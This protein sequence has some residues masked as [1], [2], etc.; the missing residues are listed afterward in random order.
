[1]RVVD[2]SSQVGASWWPEARD[3]LDH[4]RVAGS[5]LWNKWDGRDRPGHH[6]HRPLHLCCHRN[7]ARATSPP[8]GRR[9]SFKKCTC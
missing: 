4:T 8:G 3:P 6:C 1:M 7:L 9:G 2:T 5:R